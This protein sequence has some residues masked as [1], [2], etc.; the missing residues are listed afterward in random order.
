MASVIPF[1]IAFLKRGFSVLGRV[2]KS[3]ILKK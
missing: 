3:T 1:F 2:S